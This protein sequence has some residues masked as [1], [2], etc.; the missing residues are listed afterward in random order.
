M[1]YIL[2]KRCRYTGVREVKFPYSNTGVAP[3]SSWSCANSLPLH[4]IAEAKKYVADNLPWPSL[5]SCLHPAPCPLIPTWFTSTLPTLC[6]AARE[7]KCKPSR[8]GSALA[9]VL[10]LLTARRGSVR[11]CVSQMGINVYRRKINKIYM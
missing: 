2:G 11:S 4:S 8:L 9:L 10:L 7:G 3:D 6:L 1:T 5:L